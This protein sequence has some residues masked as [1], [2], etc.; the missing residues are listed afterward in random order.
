VSLPTYIN[1]LNIKGEGGRS[2]RE[3][4]KR[5]EENKENIFGWK[6]LPCFPFSMV[7]GGGTEDLSEGFVFRLVDVVADGE[8]TKPGTMTILFLLT[9]F[10]TAT[11]V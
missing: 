4:K 9:V 1:N 2:R 5:D 6:R 10:F 11:I 8:K 7:K 3:R